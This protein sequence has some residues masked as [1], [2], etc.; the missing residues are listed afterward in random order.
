MDLLSI[1][2]EVKHLG[3]V[4]RKRARTKR[5]VATFKVQQGYS[6]TFGYRYRPE[7]YADTSWGQ[8]AFAMPTSST[9][10]I[11]HLRLPA[12]YSSDEGCVAPRKIFLMWTGDNEMT[13]NRLNSVKIVRDENPDL[14]VV[15]V[16]PKNLDEWI[17]DGYPLHPAYEH[18]SLVHRA[19]YLRAYFM[20]HHGGVYLDIK[21]FQ[22]RASVWVDRL[23]SNP[24]V[25]AVGLPENG[26][27]V[28]PALGGRLGIDQNIHHERILYQAAHAFRPHTQLAA[29]WL[30]EVDRRLDYFHRILAEHPA[31]DPF[32]RNVDYP[33]PWFSILGAIFSPLCLRYHDRIAIDKKSVRIRLGAIELYR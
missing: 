3:F 8:G 26:G 24:S 2:R 28:T 13:P 20:Y 7:R 29:E 33:V 32:G 5:R 11:D 16:T 9:F 25:W 22:G 19:D 6:R 14:D 30:S 31:L 21:P 15:V 1:A 12:H 10:P 4:A 18:L 23:N 17:V 27:N